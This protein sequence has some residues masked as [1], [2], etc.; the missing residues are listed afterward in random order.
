MMFDTVLSEPHQWW[1]VLLLIMVVL[2]EFG[3]ALFIDHQ[4]R[5]L[6]IKEH[7]ARGRSLTVKLKNGMIL[8]LTE[9]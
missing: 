3:G 7:W 5:K 9:E 1:E 4:P 6:T 8:H 2:L